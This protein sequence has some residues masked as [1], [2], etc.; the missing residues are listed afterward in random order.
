MNNK[1]TILKSK[2]E[3]VEKNIEFE[4]EVIIDTKRK[5][6]NLYISTSKLDLKE[7]FDLRYKEDSYYDMYL[8]YYYSEKRLLI[9]IILVNDYNRKYYIY[10]PNEKELE[11]LKVK[12][13]DYI[14]EI[15]RKNN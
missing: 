6:I 13:E 9:E 4:D 5:K 12:M 7:K 14:K 11:I 10:K 3:L 15:Y 2:T 1:P 8:N